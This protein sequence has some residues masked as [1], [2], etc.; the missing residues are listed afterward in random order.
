M[1]KNTITGLIL[2]FAIFIGFSLFNSHRLKKTY[3]KVVTNAEAQF[4]RGELD[5]ART[6]YYEALRLHPNTPEVI[7]KLNEIN[8]KLGVAT[9][10]AS[11]VADTSLIQNTVANM[12]EAIVPDQAGIFSGALAGEEGFI[13]LE[14]SKVELKIALKGGK[15]YSARLKDFKTWDGRPLMLFSGDSTI[16]GFNFFTADNKAVQTNNLYFTPVSQEK[17]FIASTSPQTVTLRLNVAE[18]K[19]IEYNYTL[20]PDKYS[21]DFNALFNSLGDVIAANQNSITLDW[22]MYVPQQEKGRQNE[23]YYS[24]IKYK[25]LQDDVEWIRYRQSKPVEEA[26]LA[27]KLNWIAFQDQFFSSVVISKDYFINGTIT[28]TKMPP[29]DPK[30]IRH[31]S[32]ELGVPFNA[33]SLD[34]VSLKLY[35]GPNHISTLKKEGYNLDELVPLGKNIIKW[36]NRYV[37]IPVFNWLEK[38]IGSYGIII[39]ILTIIIKIILFP[40]TFKSYQS[41]AKMGVLKPKVDELGKKFPKKEDAMKKQQ[42]VMDLY[43][44]AG[45]NPMGGCLPTLLQMPIL[46][47]MFRFFP[48]SIELRQES[49]LW[50]TDLSTY[51]SILNLPFT[52]PWYGNHVSLF[53]LLMT[54]STILTAKMSGSNVTS[55]QPGMKLMTYMMP[56]M[57]MFLL[58]NFSAGLTYYYFLAN[59]LTYLQNVISKRFINADAV[60]ATLEENRKKPLKKSKWQQRLEAAAKQ[61]GINPPKR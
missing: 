61:R 53:T 8:K 30:Y 33:A 43:K 59:V 25:Y 26:D 60:L 3:D 31:Y 23:E 36:I 54:A 27:T 35:F 17:S 44:R 41:M 38:F 6:S 46:F 34:T 29:D 2:I 5:S 9:D 19:Y 48:V 37:I 32:T 20:Q 28:S 7:A 50:A 15:V 10:T 39:L 11:S 49:F 13:T 57:F 16:F 24:T 47:A 51:D 12:Q 40:L 4:N 56:V 1:D 42:A 18:G 14:N 58:N 55:D 52:I 22:K 21:V 45:V